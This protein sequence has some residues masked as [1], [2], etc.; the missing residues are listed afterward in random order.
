[1]T[2]AHRALDA[3][4]VGVIA[5]RLT[6]ILNEQQTALTNTAF[7]TVVRESLDLACGVF[8]TQGEMVAQ[9]LTGT[10][11][12]INTMATGVR[13]FAAAF[14]PAA[15]AP[16]DVLIT[17]DP[18]QTAGQVNDLTIVSPAFHDGAL[19]GFFASTCHAP[20]IGGRILSGEAR[21]VFEE[22]LRIPIMKLAHG[23]AMNEDLLAIVRAN[24]RTPNE[25]VGDIYA[26]VAA[27]EVGMRGLAALLEEFELPSIDPVGDEITA[28]SERAMR[29]AIRTLPNGT[30]THETGSDGFEGEVLLRVTVTVED[31]DLH[32]DFAGSS[33]QSAHGINL[34][35]NYTHA[36]AS[37]AMK[38]AIAPDVPHNAGAFRPV[39]V[40]APEGCILNCRPPA[41]VASRHLIGHCIPSLIFGAIAPAMPGRLL[42]GC[43]DSAW[44]TVW[45]GQA[46]QADAE[47]F[48][49]TLFQAGGIGARAVKDGLSAT[50]FPTGVAAVPT[51]VIEALTPMIQRRR[52]L[53]QDS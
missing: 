41:P 35:L 40:A 13:H 20:D 4:Q 38:A 46:A 5:N 12:H 8:D 1:M 37:F 6:S 19:V 16:G 31:E 39:H 32:V 44:M 42:A 53:R 27:N 48:N 25:T 24:V 14:P 49:L 29:E 45:R 33:P 9:S 17:N 22:G 7:S 2:T 47:P 30:Y 18:W 26:Q 28:R 36:Y 15:L 10:P 50:G 34:V 51:E 11:G 21:E 52:T 3:V 23:G 43:A